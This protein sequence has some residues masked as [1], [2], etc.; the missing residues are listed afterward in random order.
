MNT[1]FENLTEENLLEIDGGASIF[2]SAAA[3]SAGIGLLGLATV[4][5]G[6]GAALLIGAGAATH[7]A[8]IWLLGDSLKNAIGK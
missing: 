8:G 3:Y 5:T 7:T 6:G 1:H 2:T 4:A